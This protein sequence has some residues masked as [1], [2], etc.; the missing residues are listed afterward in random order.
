MNIRQHLA[1]ATLCLP[2]GLAYAVSPPDTVVEQADIEQILRDTAQL[3]F[4]SPGYG[5]LD[6]IN[7]CLQARLGPAPTEAAARKAAHSAALANYQM[8]KMA[9]ASDADPAAL[10]AHFCREVESS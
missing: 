8:M 6:T 1:I 10:A 2:A 9:H 3:G 4:P 7:G 5:Q